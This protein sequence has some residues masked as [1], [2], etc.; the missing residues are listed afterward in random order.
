MPFPSCLVT[1]FQSE[2]WCAFPVKM[3]FHLPADKSFFHMKGFARGRALKR[4][5][6]TIRN[7][8]I[9]MKFGLCQIKR[10]GSKVKVS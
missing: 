5:H 7:W 2:S 9:Y 6:K 3:S 1:L 10:I 8:L 4:R